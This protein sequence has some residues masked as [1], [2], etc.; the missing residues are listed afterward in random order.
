MLLSNKQIEDLDTLSTALGP[1]DA[2]PLQLW[3]ETVSKTLGY[4]PN[5]VE[6]H[7]LPA[8]GKTELCIALAS[9]ASKL[10]YVCSSYLGVTQFA[11]RYQEAPV[12]GIALFSS[13]ELLLF[14]LKL[15]ERPGDF[16]LI[17]EELPILLATS[18]FHGREVVVELESL[19]KQLSMRVLVLI[20]VTVRPDGSPL[21]YNVWAGVS[22]CIISV[23]LDRTIS[24]NSGEPLEFPTSHSTYNS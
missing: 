19:L 2:P 11:Q 12:D 13:R 21:F 5:L 4:L 1:P 17:I 24:V 10:V 18:K 3:S 23:N 22:S 6:I 14:L 8:S 20:T 9:G 7:G 15:R 16:A